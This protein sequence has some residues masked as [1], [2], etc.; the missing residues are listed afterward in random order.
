MVRLTVFL[1]LFLASCKVVTPDQFRRAEAACKA[2]GGL[3]Y[4]RADPLPFQ[5]LARCED[6]TE[7][8]RWPNP[9]ST[10]KK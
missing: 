6:G 5:S 7:L 10:R 9:P 2:H 4:F 1:L 8:I 3:S